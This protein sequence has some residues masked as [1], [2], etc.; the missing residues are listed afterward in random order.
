MKLIENKR[1]R[2]LFFSI[3][4]LGISS[5]ITQIIAIREFLTV[6]HGN[7][8]IF[9]IILANWLFLTGIGAYLGKYIKNGKIS[10]LIILQIIISFLPFLHLIIIRNLRNLFFLPGEM[11][12]IMQIFFSSLFILLPYCLISGFLLTFVCTIFSI[13]KDHTSIGKVYFID[14]IGDILGGIL[15][16][17]IF[18]YFLTPFQTIF[19]LMLTN[20]LATLF[21]GRLI[22]KG[23]VLI[24]LLMI[25]SSICFLSLDLDSITRQQQYK[26]QGL[27]F[28]AD[29]PYGNL[30]VTKT[31]NQLN[32]YE[33]GL[34]LFTTENTINN[35]ETVHYATSNSE[36]PQNIL[37]ISGGVSGTINELKKYSPE[38]IDYIELDPLII[39]LGKTYTKNLNNNVNIINK[40]ARLFIKQTNQ[41]YDL[42]I[43]G[44][45]DPSTAQFNRFYTSEFFNEAKRILNKNGIISLSLSSSENY[46]NIE[47]RT[48]NSALYN[49]LKP[50]FKN[51]LIIP[52]NKNHFIASDKEL[53][54]DIPRL[55]KSKDI[56]TSYV[57]EFYLS[58]KLTEDRIDYVKNS[59]IKDTKPN[60]DFKPITYYYHLLYWLKN[61]RLDTT[62]LAVMVILM[63]FYLIRI[64]PIP[65][66]LFT[67]GFSASSLMVIIL[68][69]F[70]ILYGYIYSMLSIII[71][72][73]ML[74]LAIGSY[75]MNK[76]LEHFGKKRFVK[77]E[78][79]IFFISLLVPVTLFLL[80]KIKD[81]LL[82]ML[83]S[84]TILPLLT[85]LIA[86]LVGMEFPLASKLFFKGR[87]E[88][89]AG[90]LYNADLIGACFGALLTS[91]L[92]IPLLGIFKVCLLVGLL[93]LISGTIVKLKA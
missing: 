57:N 12:G 38:R 64:K 51:I 50:Y 10:T 60:K 33:N 21:L 66:A 79:S 43:I 9:G 23:F 8:L 72:A 63:L 93:N 67:T 74:G 5:I 7:E 49:T 88:E 22:R 82:V 2:L 1:Q 59:L 36:T 87:V 4:A 40:D 48:L 71:T 55:I 68:I 37:L 58:A 70:Q 13:K 11:L 52:G 85:I 16:S 56:N 30:V 53:S 54:Y 45:P 15:F 42:I 25:T 39:E 75:Y 31:S 32:F 77:I 26:N 47:T 41:K 76:R 83:S 90:K 92:L 65:F 28:Q 69:G 62:L 29:T 89:T 78:I 14:N 18:I 81:N 73:F 61:F 91:A 35:E 84:Q 6:F 24:L 44:L 3:T 80:S 20:L 46:L 19:L 17:F 27:L 86:V 34:I